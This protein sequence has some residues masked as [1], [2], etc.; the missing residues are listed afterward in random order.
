VS[1]LDVAS[2]DSLLRESGHS[3]KCA[4]VVS[5]V[6]VFEGPPETRSHTSWL[7]WAQRKNGTALR[8]SSPT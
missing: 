3:S 4:R 1:P 2:I 5:R 8:I 7:I 6:F